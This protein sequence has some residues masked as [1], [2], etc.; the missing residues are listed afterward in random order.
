[1]RLGINEEEEAMKFSTFYL[2]AVDTRVVE[3]EREQLPW[4]AKKAMA[5]KKLTEH[6][7]IGR[8]TA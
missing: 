2:P 6:E 7:E 5:R 4:Q 1:M 8:R 3:R